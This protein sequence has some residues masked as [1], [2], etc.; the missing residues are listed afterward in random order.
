MSKKLTLREEEDIRKRITNELAFI[1]R[2]ANGQEDY[3]GNDNDWIA[4]VSSLLDV[5][6][7]Y[8][9]LYT[10][11]CVKLLQSDFNL[12]LRP[13]TIGTM[14]FV[15]MIVSCTESAFDWNT[16]V[17]RIMGKIAWYE[18]N[19]TVYNGEEIQSK[20]ILQI[21]KIWKVLLDSEY[22]DA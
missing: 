2:L 1:S 17:S 12:P 7:N 14:M 5:C 16:S 10:S 21:A 22:Q 19:K 9:D 20:A 11:Q 4:A 6:L 18:A 3:D 13:A 8:P 15:P